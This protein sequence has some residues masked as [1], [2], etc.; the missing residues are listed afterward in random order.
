LE[1]CARARTIAPSIAAIASVASDRAR[2]ASSPRDAN[3]SARRCCQ[4][5]N[6]VPAASR[7]APERSPSSVAETI[8]HPRRAPTSSAP[9]SFEAPIHTNDRLLTADDL[10]VRWQVPKS[11]VYRLAR[12]ARIPTVKLGRYYRFRLAAV[13]AFELKGGVSDA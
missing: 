4:R 2:S 12:G 6:A 5:A 1:R 11:H 7:A 13:E 9:D 8:G 10:A 3:A